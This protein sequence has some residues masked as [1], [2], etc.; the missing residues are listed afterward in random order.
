MSNFSVFRFHFKLQETATDMIPRWSQL[1]CM[2]QDMRQKS[3]NTLFCFNFQEEFFAVSFFL[4]HALK[5]A[6]FL[7]KV[8][9]IW[10]NA[11]YKHMY[12]R[13]NG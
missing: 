1:S 6:H 9:A 8:C 12:N 2:L 10:R 3:Q 7:S 11:R 13:E 4:L 5:T